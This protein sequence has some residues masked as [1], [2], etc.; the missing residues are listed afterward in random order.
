MERKNITNT[1]RLIISAWNI[2]LFATVWIGYYNDF[3]FD[4]YWVEGAIMSCIIY[5]IIYFAMCNV[6]KAF[7]IAS[8]S[9]GEIV[10]AQVIAFGLADLILYVECCLIYN[11]MVNL[12]PGITTVVAQLSGSALTVL[13]TKR[14]FMHHVQP[15]DTMIIYGKNV[16][17]DETRRFADR[18]L[19]KYKHL[20]A[21]KRIMQENSEIDEISHEMGNYRTVILYEVSAVNRGVYLK[22]CS[23]MHKNFYYTP[24]VEDLI[25]QGATYKRLLDTPL[26]KYEYNYENHREYW[27]KRLFDIVF[28]AC[29]LIVLAPLFLIVAISIKIED[30]GPVFYRQARCTKGGKVFWMIKFRSMVVDAEKDGVIP[31]VSND[32]RI[33]KV[34]RVIR[35]YRMD[36][37]PQLINIL[38]GDMSVVGPRPERVEH[39]QQY[40]KEMP[41][42]A[43]RLRVKGGLTGYAQI[44]GKY[45][46]SA[47]DKLRLDLM[48]IEHQSLLEDLKIIM[49][50][51]RTVFQKEST[52]GFELEKSE[53]IHREARSRT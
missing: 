50:T 43:Y 14:F 12:W 9:V 26:M 47:Y 42:F 21:I 20:F 24:N 38:Q 45:N 28:S 31:C 36:E 52:E 17:A 49:L 25:T 10:F 35:K 34:G 4:K 37:L 32:A 48:Y 3:T 44:F 41:E 30:G 1:A 22:L 23:E 7:R 16:S 11:R 29:M 6:Y 18:L 15:K 8:T 13:C 51:F 19:Y 5:S 27:V 40:T 46:S 2:G 39:V 53:K 33:T